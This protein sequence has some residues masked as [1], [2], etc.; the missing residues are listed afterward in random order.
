MTCE[1]ASTIQYGYWKHGTH[2]QV[3]SKILTHGNIKN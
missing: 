1:E 3:L 2:A